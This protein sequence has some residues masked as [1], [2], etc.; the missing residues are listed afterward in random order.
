VTGDKQTRRLTT[1]TTRLE[2]LTA[3][4]DALIVELRA[5][6]MSLRAIGALAGLTHVGV[7]RILERVRGRI[8]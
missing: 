7:L 2:T 4:R 6:G 8:S 5:R 3:E 1:V